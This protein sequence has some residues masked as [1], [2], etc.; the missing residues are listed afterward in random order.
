MNSLWCRFPQRASGLLTT[1][2][3]T[4]KVAWGA[5]WHISYA[6][7]TRTTSEHTWRTCVTHT[8][9]TC[10]TRTPR[11][12]TWRTLCD[13]HTLPV[14]HAH[15][16]DKHLWRT[17]C[18]CRTRSRRDRAQ[19]TKMCD[20]HAESCSRHLTQYA[21]ICH[22]AHIWHNTCWTQNTLLTLHISNTRH[23]SNT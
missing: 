23:I 8:Y 20:E 4:S 14:S 9:F 13:A 6:V 15:G 17:C 7:R 21:Y 18:T 5:Q 11:E 2:N 16:V 22:I 19:M 3:K 12:H 1:S 10:S